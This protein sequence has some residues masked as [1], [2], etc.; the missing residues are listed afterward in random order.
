MLGHSEIILC[1]RIDSFV[2]VYLYFPMLTELSISWAC[3]SS[4]AGTDRL[5]LVF[6]SPL[7]WAD[8]VAACASCCLLLLRSAPA[9]RWN[10]SSLLAGHV[11]N[12]LWTKFSGENTSNFKCVVCHF[13]RERKPSSS[14][15]KLLQG[16]V[17]P[18]LGPLLFR[19][20]LVS[21]NSRF[22]E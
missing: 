2:R 9:R 19:G 8:S 14:E 17:G 16:L 20:P 7:L 5:V 18:H 3:T 21:R 11:T 22:K 4:Q 1:G 13:L 12:A 6:G 10:C 15:W